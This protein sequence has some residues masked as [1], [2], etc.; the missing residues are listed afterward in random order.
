MRDAIGHD[1]RLDSPL[2]PRE[3]SI[4]DGVLMGIWPDAQAGIDYARKVWGWV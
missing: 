4:L 2:T 3:Q 1:V